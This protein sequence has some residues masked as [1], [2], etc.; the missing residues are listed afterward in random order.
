M[1]FAITAMNRLMFTMKLDE[2]D[3]LDNFEVL[4]EDWLQK[5]LQDCDSDYVPTQVDFWCQRER[6]FGYLD[7]IELVCTDTDYQKCLAR[8]TDM[9]AVVEKIIQTT[10]PKGIL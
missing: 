9:S 3:I 5:T 7:V 10:E 2:H 8:L 4:L 6:L 1:K